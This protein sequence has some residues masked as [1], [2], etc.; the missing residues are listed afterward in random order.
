MS[1]RVILNSSFE[2]SRRQV[3]ST[4][5]GASLAG[6][7]SGCGQQRKTLGLVENMP[8]ERQ[9]EWPLI[10]VAY[11]RP[12]ADYWLGWPGTAFDVKGYYTK[13][14]AQ[15]EQFA[16][17]LKVRVAFEPEPL[18]EKADNNR[19]IQKVKQEKPDGILIM[20]MHMDRWKL[21]DAIQKGLEGTP[22]IIFAPLG[23]CF[24]GHIQQISKR[25]G[26]YLASCA[27]F[28]LN[29]VRHGMKMIRT[30][31]D[32]RRSKMVVLKEE[33]NKD[34]LLEPLG[35]T[36]RYRPVNHFVEVLETIEETPQVVALAREYQR[37]AKKVVEP[38][39]QDLINAS[40]NYFASLKIMKELD[41]QGI[42]M[43]CL[44]LV[45]KKHIDCPPCLAWSK[46]LDMG[47]PGVC[48]ADVRAVMGHALTCRL[49][50]KPGFMQD[51]VPNTVNNTLIGAHC[52]APTRLN[53]YDQPREPF[54][55]RS[56][57][58][59]DLGV[60]VQVLWREGQEVTIMQMTDPGTMILGKGT[61]LR[62]LS[63]PPAGGCRTSVELEIDAPA[64]TRDTKG[65]HQLFIYGNHMRD[66]KDY[67]QMFG[68]KCEHI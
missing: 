18:Y 38:T 22:T 63:T 19:F 20:P 64:D 25:P 30:H 49:L 36:I 29:P 9:D 68:I 58:E 43:Q 66:F 46:L 3:I 45:H 31:H 21:V 32:M 33:L 5:A 14:K 8:R 60:A 48:E 26:V 57:S 27:D 11:L 34:E 23:M 47:I 56:H 40:K 6:L 17:Q 35:L 24:T 41:C 52:V 54:N 42:S 7:A 15:I 51:P 28:D 44:H 10:R 13:S 55:L 2:L 53:G 39:W 67:G 1:K 62:N 59:S 4:V 65:F 61:V 12:K 37:A 50:D 16:K